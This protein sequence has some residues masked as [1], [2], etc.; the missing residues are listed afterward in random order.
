[1]IISSCSPKAFLTLSP[2]VI[3]YILF[4]ISLLFRSF[5]PCELVHLTLMLCNT[6]SPL[7][8]SVHCVL[9]Q[10]ELITKGTTAAGTKRTC[11]VYVCK[12]L[13]L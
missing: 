13:K 1:M 11:A 8:G 9:L 3:S 12:G 6:N 7:P 2:T 4:T 10:V 5:P